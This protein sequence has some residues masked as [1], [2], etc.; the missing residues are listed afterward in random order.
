M[1]LTEKLCMDLKCFAPK[2]LALNPVFP[3]S[4]QNILIHVVGA[5]NRQKETKIV[6][7]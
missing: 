1:Q 4:S 2:N 3:Q 7:E 5:Q 6:F